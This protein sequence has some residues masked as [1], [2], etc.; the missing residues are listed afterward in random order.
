ML[1]MEWSAHLS[2]CTCSTMTK[3]AGQFVLLIIYTMMGTVPKATVTE[4]K[5]HICKLL[6]VYYVQYKWR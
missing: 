1:R 2:I 4:H 6:N 3:G 5:G